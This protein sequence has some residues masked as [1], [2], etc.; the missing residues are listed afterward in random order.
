MSTAKTTST[1]TILD[2]IVSARA[3]EI[4]RQRCAVSLD[5]VR[6]AAES[7][8]PALDFHGALAKPGIS[9]I[10]EMK[11]KSPSGG[12]LR[13]DLDPADTARTYVNSGAS[14]LSI[15][16]EPFYFDG[17]MSDMRDAGQAAHSS[18][19]PVLQ[20]DFVFDE[21]QIYE[22]RANGA[23]AILLIVAILDES[24]LRGLHSLA[25]EL[26]MA[27]LM[28]VFD[29]EELEL[30]MKIDPPILG[31]NNRNL[32]TL[33]TSLAHFEEI[34]AQMDGERVLVAESGMKSAADVRRMEAA[35][36]DAVLV[37]EALMRAGSSAGSLAS[38]ITGQAR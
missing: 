1:G 13:P 27:A 15:L 12:E 38:E 11:R 7:A 29:R 20:K 36:A 3:T 16:T 14:A 5:G 28:E 4:D 8:P 22:A 9:L 21:Y 10:A 33:E 6:T 26:G 25:H 24:S 18:G 2:E 34:A 35:G 19:V 23:D 17:K 37:G 30:A 31:V 32:K